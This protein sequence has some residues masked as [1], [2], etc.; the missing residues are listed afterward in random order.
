MLRTFEAA[1]ARSSSSFRS[2][3]IR[4]EGLLTEL[5]LY[6]CAQWLFCRNL[7]L[8]NFYLKLFSYNVYFRQ[9]WA[10]KSIYFPISIHH[11]SH[12]HVVTSLLRVAFCLYQEWAHLVFLYTLLAHILY[13]CKVRSCRSKNFKIPP[14]F[15]FLLHVWKHESIRTFETS[16][17][18]IYLILKSIKIYLN[19]KSIKIYLILKIIKIY[20]ILK[21]IKQNIE[22]YNFCYNY[23][24]SIQKV[25]RLLVAS[26]DGYLY[27]YNLDM[28]EGKECT[29]WKQHR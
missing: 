14:T 1:N 12:T 11:N 16:L 6:M 24:C 15:F 21:S 25:L 7:I 5:P 3:D 22:N 10:L 26:S 9:H 18:K 8:N 4:W 27:V 23:C 2:W 19:R 20:L 17:L 29:L 13:V 28:P